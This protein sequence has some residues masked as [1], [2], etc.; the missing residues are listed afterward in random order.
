[1]LWGFC[2]LRGI[3]EFRTRPMSSLCWSCWKETT[4]TALIPWISQSATR[5]PQN[6]KP[7]QARSAAHSVDP[8]KDIGKLPLCMCK[9]SIFLGGLGVW[10]VHAK[11]QLAGTC[12]NIFEHGLACTSSLNQENSRNL[13]SLTP[14]QLISF[15][16][17]TAQTGPVEKSYLWLER[18]KA[19]TH[20]SCCSMYWTKN[21][22]NKLTTTLITAC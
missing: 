18:S 21:G 1:M 6:L 8:W 16:G 3:T 9:M 10:A 12:S 7:W 14:L 15:T 17:C 22:R 13:L 11:R 2:S 5:P 4:K 20:G 19:D